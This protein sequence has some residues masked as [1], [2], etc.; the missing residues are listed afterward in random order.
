MRVAVSS[1]GVWE[2]R[3]VGVERIVEGETGEEEGWIM[4]KGRCREVCRGDGVVLWVSGFQVN[5]VRG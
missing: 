2:I 5:R 1:V 4:C 3:L